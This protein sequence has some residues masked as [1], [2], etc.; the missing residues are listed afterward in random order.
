MKIEYILEKEDYLTYLLYTEFTSVKAKRAIRNGKLI[1]PLAFFG[2]GVIFL[3]LNLI[4]VACILTAIG[5][6]YTFYYTSSVKKK[7][8]LQYKEYVEDVYRYRFGKKTNLEITNDLIIET[9]DLTECKY[10]ISG[11]K[12]INEIPTA[13]YLKMK[14]GGS[15]IIP[16]SRI[17]HIRVLKSNLEELATFLQIKYIIDD[18]WK[19]I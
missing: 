2:L 3:F 6:L 4:I 18:D 16:K 10:I 9:N 13:I 14:S 5:I 17:N 11:I 12:E 8:Y 1:V 15:I 19:W 7:F